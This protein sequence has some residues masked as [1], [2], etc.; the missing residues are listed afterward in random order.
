MLSP[1]ASSP[2]RFFNSL[3]PPLLVGG[4]QFLQHLN[5]FSDQLQPP[6][7]PPQDEDIRPI[8]AARRRD[9][10]VSKVVDVTGEKVREYFE[11][12]LELFTDPGVQDTQ[13]GGLVYLAQIHAMKE[14]DMQTMYVDYEHLLTVENGV[15]AQAIQGDYYRYLPFLQSGLRRTI[16][17]HAPEILNVPSALDRGSE[18][19]SSTTLQLELN[20]RVFQIA[21]YNLP[22]LNRIRDIRAERIGKLMA[23]LGTV[24]RTLEVRP[25]L[26]KASFTCDL[27][28]AVVDGIEQIFKFTEPSV[29]TN[30]TCQNQAFWTLNVAKL[31]FLD[32]QRVRIQENPNEIPTGL[33]PRTLDVILRGECVERAKPGDKCKF[34]G[35]EIVVPDVTQLGLPG[36]KPSTT[37]DGRGAGADLNQGILGLKALG[38]RDLTYKIAF[39]A[40]HVALLVNKQSS[41]NSE[42]QQAFRHN[43]DEVEDRH[44]Q[45][46]FLQTLTSGELAELRDM[47]KDDHV[48]HKLVQLVA[49]AV[50]GHE[51][52][53][54][55]VLLQMLGGVHKTTV[56]GIN[57]R[58]D[59]NICIVGDPLCSKLQ[60]LKYVCGFAPRAIYTSG[61]ALS[62]AGLTAAVVRDEES[63]EFTI[64]AGALMLAD[65]GICAIDE[66]DKMDIG[67]QVAIHE[68]ME[69]QTISIA[70]AGIHA[71]LNARALIL[72]AANPIGGRYNRKYGLRQNLNM[73][74]PIMLRF[75]LFFVILDDSNERVDTQLASHIVDLHMLQDSA[76]TLPYTA[77]QLSRYISYAKTFK[78]RMT[79]EARDFLVARYKELRADDAQGLGRSSYRITVR[80]L[81]LMIRLSEAIARA[82]CAEEI[83]QGFVGEAYDLLRQSI[84]RVDMDD[85]EVEEEEEEVE[86]AEGM[87]AVAAAVAASQGEPV[88]PVE[89]RPT[90]ALLYD[91]YVLIMN[92]LVRRVNDDD[93]AGG[94][95]LTMDQ[96]LEWYLTQREEEI[97]SEAEY[98]DERRLAKKVVKRL[99]K[100]RILM[101]VRSEAEAGEGET[102]V[103]YILHP[104][105]A[106][107]DFFDQTGSQQQDDEME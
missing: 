102:R 93:R 74:A 59:I 89:A 77:E 96:L 34:T 94:E 46:M 51:V 65:N 2:G 66:F 68:A 52:V 19:G 36:V 21:F 53:K 10:A 28:R 35:M 42:L 17:K 76:I 8:D 54:K 98:W 26:Y 32:W 25:E 67:D 30:P 18:A 72:A 90:T 33:M 5:L 7:Q 79:K 39:F 88:G 29:C 84:I 101:E 56:D 15:L 40:C 75:D 50:Y 48:Y 11:A 20:E 86:G 13:F 44:A 41:G 6:T 107:L 63:G 57:L 43:Q 22:T 81:E 64:E 70:K 23:I 80:Q 14:Y 9:V 12:F 103:V 104:N 91:R 24:T 87:Q 71:T 37:R 105:C 95:G 106:I 49:P 62:A 47:V 3:Q 92:L 1:Q 78:P 69:Q 73:T 60:F 97:H 100:D 45:E 16:R 55:G 38:V 27:C 31:Q 82:N 99:V 4:L 85:V 83:T 61:K 58:G